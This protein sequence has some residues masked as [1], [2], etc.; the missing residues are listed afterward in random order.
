[1]VTFILLML[2]I[3]ITAVIFGIATLLHLESLEEDINAL[4]KNLDRLSVRVFRIE[5]RNAR[6]ITSDD[7]G[8]TPAD[9]DE[10]ETEIPSF[11]GDHE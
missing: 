7:L 4:R 3:A 11:I 9:E 6:F 8:F 10:D 1:M 5:E 2:A